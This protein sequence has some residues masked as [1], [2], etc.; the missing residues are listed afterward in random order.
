MGGYNEDAT[1]FG[2]YD[3][4]ASGA[5]IFFE[6][7]CV[8][9]AVHVTHQRAISFI[10]TV[11]QQSNQETYNQFMNILVMHNKEKNSILGNWGS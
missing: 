11:Q 4:N 10:H 6:E 2:G 1:D 3:E 5:E 8:D 7:H 9:G